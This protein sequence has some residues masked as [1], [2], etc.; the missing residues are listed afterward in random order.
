MV[1]AIIAQTLIMEG[2]VTPAELGIITPFRAQIAEIKRYLPHELQENEDLIIDT[3]ERY[4]G[5]ERKVIIFS[6]TVA[7][8]VQVRNMQN[9]SLSDPL[10]TDRKLLV[11][12]SRA[13]EQLIVLGNSSALQAADGYRDMISYMKNHNGYLSR[14]WAEGVINSNFSK[15][16][17]D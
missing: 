7:S 9:I 14:E 13:E 4:Q 12:I 15:I 8:A 16:I 2:V 10:R 5:D 11:S 17:N 6:T 1:A 3:V